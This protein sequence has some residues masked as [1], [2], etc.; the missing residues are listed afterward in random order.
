M[1]NLLR[2]YAAATFASAAAAGHASQVANDLEVF[3]RV[4]MDSEPLHN[5]LTD[6]SIPSR[7]RSGV[8]RDLL[9][10]KGAAETR[11]LVSWAVLVEVPAEIP[12]AIFEL[13]G[14]AH[15]TADAAEAG[16]E[17]ALKDEELLGGRSAV[18]ERIRGF[19][20]RLFQKA[21]SRES[22]DQLEDEVV[23]FARIVESSRELRQALVD[24][25]RP[26]GQRVALVSGLLHDKVQP[27]TEHLVAYV[28]KA[29]HVRDL[30]GT[31][32]WLAGLA[33]EERGRRVA[34]VRSAVELD[35][36]EYRRLTQALE[37]SAGHPVEVR[38]QIEP[39][40]MGGMAVEIGDTVIDGSVRRRLDQLRDSLAPPGGAQVAS[41]R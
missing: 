28:I 14:L 3:A 38:V 31:L 36:A 2:G 1:R 35:E 29:G 40:L 30:V 39:L 24:P 27:S 20:D 34:N 9:E 7:A 22:I 37:R 41:R 21:D 18:R 6:G 12:A 32:E 16:E 25:N 23:G 17:V 10:E 19:A 8:V 4:L 5:V 11:E 33:A 15:E 26:V 13:E